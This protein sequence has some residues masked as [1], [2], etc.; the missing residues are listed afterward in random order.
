MTA[1]QRGEAEVRDEAAP[2]RPPRT[3]LE[4]LSRDLDRIA[5]MIALIAEREADRRERGARFGCPG[6][7]QLEALIAARRARS[8]AFRLELAHPGWTLILLLAHARLA[9]V[10]LHTGD[11]PV[12]ARVA[13]ATAARWLDRLC[14]NG[15]ARR[16]PDRDRPSRTLA[17]LT[18]AGAEAV[19]DYFAA[20]R[21][22]D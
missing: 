2:P 17:E 10:K 7:D 14:A 8:A 11:L 18:D 4:D 5:A 21:L 13:P 9:G 20:V 19:R 22:G 1:D 16:R 6:A 3:L 12:A 15:H